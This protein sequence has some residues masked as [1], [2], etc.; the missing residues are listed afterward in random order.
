M[1]VLLGDMP[2]VEPDFLSLLAAAAAPAAT[3]QNDG[4]PG[5]PALLSKAM[6]ASLCNLEGDRGA[7]R[8][9][10]EQPDLTSLEAPAGMLI[11]IDRPEDL[12]R[13]EKRLSARGAGIVLP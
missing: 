10:A 4:Q 2:L 11:D 8:L 9:L 1:L 12:F 7:A 6:Y 3:I 13:A 5:A